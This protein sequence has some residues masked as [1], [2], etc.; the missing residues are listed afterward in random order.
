M[1]IGLAAVVYNENAAFYA[2]CVLLELSGD[3]SYLQVVRY[4]PVLVRDNGYGD[5]DNGELGFLSLACLGHDV[6][7]FPG[8]RVVELARFPVETV[9][10]ISAESRD[11]FGLCYEGEVVRRKVG[12]AFA[13]GP[14]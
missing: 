8:L 6:P 5:R 14:V 9:D 11:E 1:P 3:L 10:D 12:K 2:L 13:S 7:L 4:C